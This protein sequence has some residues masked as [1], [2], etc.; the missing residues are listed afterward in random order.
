MLA[1]PARNSPSNSCNAACSA[2]A[3]S[4]FPEITKDL[5]HLPPLAPLDALVKIL[6]RPA[7]LFG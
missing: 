7:Q 5:W 1:V 3:K 6:K 2:T 4:R